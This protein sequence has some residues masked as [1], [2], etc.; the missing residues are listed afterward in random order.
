MKI[1][2]VRSVEVAAFCVTL[3]WGG[4]FCFAGLF[5]SFDGL[6]SVTRAGCCS[7]GMVLLGR[8]EFL[9]GF[10]VVCWWV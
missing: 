5:E 10:L 2:K 6:M 1:F 4:A 3:A 9:G 7:V 8:G